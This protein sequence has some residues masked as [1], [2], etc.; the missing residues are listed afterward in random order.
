V[1]RAELKTLRDAMRKTNDELDQARLDKAKRNSTAMQAVNEKNKN[2]EKW[3]RDEGIQRTQWKALI[4]VILDP[5]GDML[6]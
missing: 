3:M 6:W 2:S 4:A 1:L 5:F